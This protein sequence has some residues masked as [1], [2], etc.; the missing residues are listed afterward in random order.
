MSMPWWLSDSRNTSSTIASPIGSDHSVS[1]PLQL[2]RSRHLP[3]TDVGENRPANDRWSSGRAGQRQRRNPGD[4]WHENSG[5]LSDSR[6]ITSTARYRVGSSGVEQTK[7]EYRR[8][9]IIV[10]KPNRL[11]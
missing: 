7:P 2:G 9:D 3:S 10:H 5:S 11:G 8:Y 4:P 1:H 6:K